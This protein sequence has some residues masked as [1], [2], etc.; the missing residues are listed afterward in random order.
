MQA[1]F[2]GKLPRGKI[3]QHSDAKET[4]WPDYTM[5]NTQDDSVEPSFILGIV[6]EIDEVQMMD[7]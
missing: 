3:R 1:V 2:I 7:D 5:A 4:K 6:P